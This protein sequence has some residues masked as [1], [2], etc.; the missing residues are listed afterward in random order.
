M[1]LPKGVKLQIKMSDIVRFNTKT[2]SEY[3]K[4]RCQAMN[5]RCKNILEKC[6]KCGHKFKK[7]EDECPQCNSEK[8]C[9]YRFLKGETK[10]RV[11]GTKRTQCNRPT[12]KGSKR[13]NVHNGLTGH[14]LIEICDKDIQQ[15][16]PTKED[17]KNL[18]VGTLMDL[19]YELK[20]YQKMLSDLEQMI[21]KTDPKDLTKYILMVNKYWK[22]VIS[23]Y[24][25]IIDRKKVIERVPEDL[26]KKIKEII[27]GVDKQS[28][29]SCID[30]F[31][32]AMIKND[33]GDDVINKIINLLPKEM[34]EVYN[35]KK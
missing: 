11:C 4:G 14:D 25:Q 8:K 33:I 19:D 34:Q 10:C 6:A 7:E 20:K 30:A 21:D 1:R 16:D 31:V 35:N 17:Q 9:N 27:A 28:T 18:A 26:D 13:C 29:I 2:M 24:Y 5:R 3:K 32:G 23:N 15:Y 22:D 12:T